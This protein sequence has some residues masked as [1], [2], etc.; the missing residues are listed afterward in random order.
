MPCRPP[1]APRT[2]PSDSL[3]APAVGLFFCP[4]PT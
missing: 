2:L 3:T 4:T 1:L